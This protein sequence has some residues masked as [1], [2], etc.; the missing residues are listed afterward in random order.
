MDTWIHG[1]MDT[2]I[3]T[4]GFREEYALE[5]EKGGDMEKEQEEGGKRRWWHW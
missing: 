1:Y 2:C 4:D 3:D 5:A